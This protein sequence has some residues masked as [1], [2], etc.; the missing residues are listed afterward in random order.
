MLPYHIGVVEVFSKHGLVDGQTKWLGSSGGAL[1]ATAAALQLDMKHQLNFCIDSGVHAAQSHALGPLG[2]MSH[3]IAPHIKESLPADAH[4][5]CTGRLFISVTETPQMDCVY[6]NRIISQY[7]SVGQV[8][9]ALIASTYIPVYY[10]RPAK[11]GVGVFYYDGGFSCNQP[12]FFEDGV[13]VTTTVSPNA[14][15]ADVCPGRQTSCS[16][17]HLFPGGVEG[18][19]ENYNLGKRV[20]ERYVGRMKELYGSW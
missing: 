15:A 3:Y 10:E 18:A 20:G 1:I 14:G 2:V 11:P 16:I 5:R 4:T 13:C 7:G 19:M 9:D 8:Y 12:V 17:E 6:G